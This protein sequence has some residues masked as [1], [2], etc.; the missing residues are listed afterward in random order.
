[1][2]A[3]TFSTAMAEALQGMTLAELARRTGLNRQQLHRYVNGEALPRADAFLRICSVLSLNPWILT[4]GGPAGAEK[5]SWSGR[6]SV[7]DLVGG[8]PPPTESQLPSGIYEAYVG[9]FARAGYVLRY[10][11]MICNGPEGRTTF[12]RVPSRLYPSDTPA[13]FR[14]VRG[15]LVTKF[16]KTVMMISLSVAAGQVERKVAVG[17]FGPPDLRFGI[18]LGITVMLDE[19]AVFSPMATRTALVPTNETSY[20]RVFRRS[21][22]VALEDMPRPVR[23]HY[24]APRFASHTL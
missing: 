22:M 14:E 18:R 10:A 24:E 19:S 3:T 20:P 1:M 17:H 6:R 21:A 5:Q 12:A 11:L 8:S 15:H 23:D 9:R 2:T 4:G 7:R 16:D 13:M